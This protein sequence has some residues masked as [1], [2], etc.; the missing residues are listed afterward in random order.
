VLL[1]I[2]LLAATIAWLVLAD[3]ANEEQKKRD[4]S[5]HD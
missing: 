4:L 2:A 5:N 1:V 3:A